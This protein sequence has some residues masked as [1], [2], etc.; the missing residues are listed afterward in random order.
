M[1][2]GSQETKGLQSDWQNDI[3]KTRSYECSWVSGK[4]YEIDFVGGKGVRKG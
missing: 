4:D 3:S 1:G 2:D